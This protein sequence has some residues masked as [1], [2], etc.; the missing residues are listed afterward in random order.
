MGTNYYT[1]KTC[2]HCQHEDRLHIGKS[3]VGWCFALNTHQDKGITSLDDWRKKFA[4]VGVV[5]VDEYERRVTVEDMLSTIT[6]RSGSSDRR[7]GD[8]TC[9]PGPNGLRRSR[10][11]GQRCI[12]H[13]VG[14]W[15]IMRGDFH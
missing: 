11:D 7:A 12:A 5:I 15:D 9:E 1:T 4:E 3:S 14:T 6:E 10:V 8:G 2:G 13:G